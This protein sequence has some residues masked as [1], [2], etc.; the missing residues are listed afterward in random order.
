MATTD[1]GPTPPGAPSP[2]VTICQS[3][4][5]FADCEKQVAQGY[6]PSCAGPSAQNS[7]P[8]PTGGSYT[9]TKG[10]SSVS[11]TGAT[12]VSY[13][14]PGFWA[15]IG[16]QAGLVIVALVL[17][18]AGFYLAFSNQINAAVKKAV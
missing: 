18:G 6:I 15:T 7:V 4:A 2:G 12:P 5:N 14:A 11:Y 8:A 9:G 17:V 10:S 3:C 16:Q 13:F 1:N